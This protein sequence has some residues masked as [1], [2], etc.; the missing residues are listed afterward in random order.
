MTCNRCMCIHEEYPGLA[1][2]VNTY[3]R[4]YACTAHVVDD[5]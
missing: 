5:W 2:S 4:E 1:L 3:I